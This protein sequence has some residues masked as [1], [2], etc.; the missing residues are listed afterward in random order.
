M[1]NMSTV[2]EQERQGQ[3]KGKA[4]SVNWLTFPDLCR[5]FMGCRLG[6]VELSL[7]QPQ[8]KTVVIRCEDGDHYLAAIHREGN[9]L[10]F[11]LGESC[12]K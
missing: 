8:L 6:I 1:P 12:Q 10:V 2:R 4:A 3:E 7:V 5:Q 9:T 11:D